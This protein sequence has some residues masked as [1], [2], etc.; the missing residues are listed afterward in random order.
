MTNIRALARE[1][2]LSKE[3]VDRVMVLPVTFGSLVEVFLKNRELLLE[4]YSSDPGVPLHISVLESFQN[5]FPNLMEM[6]QVVV[7]GDEDSSNE[8]VYGIAVNR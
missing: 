5:D 8:L 4:E 3:D 2:K 1:G 7:V 6:S